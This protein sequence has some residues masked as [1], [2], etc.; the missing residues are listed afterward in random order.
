MRNLWVAEYSQQQK[1]YHVD[2]MVDV[3]R[4]NLEN[5]EYGTDPGY[6]PIGVFQTDNEAYEFV[7]LHRKLKEARPA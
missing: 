1:C 7:A 5:I 2:P 4:H 6:I 3:L